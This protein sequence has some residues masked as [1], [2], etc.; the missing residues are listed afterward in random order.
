MCLPVCLE[1]TK[2]LPC[3]SQSKFK[4]TCANVF[5]CVYICVHILSPS[6]PPSLPSIHPCLLSSLTHSHSP[7]LS[8][9]GGAKSTTAGGAK[10]T[11]TTIIHYCDS[12]N[13]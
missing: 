13:G 1:L 5:I 4:Y 9:S 6:L 2:L 11:T 12:H 7:S 10:S 8:L 3:I